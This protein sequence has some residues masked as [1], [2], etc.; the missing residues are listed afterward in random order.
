MRTAECV[1]LHRYLH[2]A[3]KQSVRVQSGKFQCRHT[4]S[5]CWNELGCRRSMSSETVLT[6]DGR[7]PGGRLRC[8]KSIEPGDTSLSAIWSVD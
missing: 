2:Q 7:K 8:E 6:C 1:L 5:S 4:F 3:V